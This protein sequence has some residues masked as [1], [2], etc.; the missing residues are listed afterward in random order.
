MWP[1]NNTT[2]TFR[3]PE[4]HRLSIRKLG[5]GVLDLLKGDGPSQSLMD[6]DD[7]V[8]VL[9]LVL[10]TKHFGHGRLATSLLGLG[11]LATSLLPG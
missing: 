10:G 3:E 4:H 9:G 1:T 5:K 8:A 11:R 6:L 7:R 2:S